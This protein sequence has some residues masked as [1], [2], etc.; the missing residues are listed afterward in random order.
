MRYLT[1]SFDKYG[2]DFSERRRR[3]EFRSRTEAKAN[4]AKLPG[5]I[6]DDLEIIL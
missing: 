2:V 5:D 1:T 4:K 3:G 6:L